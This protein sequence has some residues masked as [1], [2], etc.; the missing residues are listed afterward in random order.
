[1]T[2]L[3]TPDV[4][5]VM[6]FTPNL[7]SQLHVTFLAH[8]ANVNQVAPQDIVEAITSAV[9]NVKPFS[10]T[11]SGV[12]WFGVENNKPVQ[13]FYETVEASQLHQVLCEAA[14]HQG[15]ILNQAEFAGVGFSPH[16]SLKKN[17]EAVDVFHVGS[18][19]ISQHVG[20]FGG[21]VIN[22]PAI[23]LL[24]STN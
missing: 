17:S 9:T 10:L 19:V 24:S 5:F 21:P 16:M 12:A 6:A 11:K 14:E 4:Y 23:P 20:G 8:A 3:S 7:S 2:D 1:M 18:L 15:M 22:H 13:T